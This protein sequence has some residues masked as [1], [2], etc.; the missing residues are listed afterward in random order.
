MITKLELYDWKSYA[1]AEL[2][3]DPLSILI[4]TN[5][6]GKSN[7]LDALLLLNRVSFGAMLTSAL[8]GDS[9][10]SPVRG[11][12]EWAARKPGSVFA[13][14]IVCCGDEF[15]DYEYRLEGEI[16]E[17]RCDLYSE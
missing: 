6:S 17:S 10:L 15:T 13:V 3:I 5:A 12:I 7:A 8:K 9:A 11:G 16:V 1:T 14:G 4:G 2:H